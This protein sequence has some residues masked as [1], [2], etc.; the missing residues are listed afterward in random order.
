MPVKIWL[1]WKR[2]IAW[3]R[4]CN[5]KFLSDKF[6]ETSPSLVAFTLILEKLLTFE[7]SAGIFFAHVRG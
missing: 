2:Q 4:I 5:I 3:R 7:V 1:L 6:Q